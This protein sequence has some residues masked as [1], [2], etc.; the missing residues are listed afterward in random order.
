MWSDTKQRKA[1]IKY[2]R[3]NMIED[4]NNHMNSTDNTNQLR[5]NYQPDRWMRQRKCGG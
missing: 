2:L 5:G 4:Y 1:L 3:L